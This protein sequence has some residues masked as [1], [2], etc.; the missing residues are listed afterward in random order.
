M[1][2]L[3]RRLPIGPRLTAAFALMLLTMAAITAVSFFMLHQADQHVRHIVEVNMRKLSLCETMS[4]QVHVASRVLRSMVLLQDGPRIEAEAAHLTEIRHAYDAAWTALLE[5]PASAEGLQ[6][7]ERIEAMKQRTREVNDRIVA[8]ARANRDDEARELLMGESNRDLSAWQAALDDNV[9]LQE[10]QNALEA[11]ELLAANTAAKAMLLAITLGA[12]AA[13]ALAAL[14]ITRSI[15]TPIDTA[16]RTAEAIQAGRLDT[17]VRAEG[18]DECARLL[19]AMGS[20]QQALRELVDTVRQNAESVA[21]ASAE[22]A[23]GSQDLSGRTEQQASALEQTAASMEQLSSA[24]R[25]NADNAAQAN[26]LANDASQVAAEGGEKMGR[27]VETMAAIQGSSRQIAEI[28]GVIDSIA[29]QTNLLALNAAVEAARAGEQGRGFAVVAGEVRTLAQRSADAARQIKALI[30]G[31]VEQIQVGSELVGAAGGTID[32]MVETTRHVTALI[33]EIHVAS[34][35]QS[36]G[37]D[38]VRDAVAQMDHVT[39]QNAALVEESAAAA[40]SLQVQSQ[41]LVQAVHRFHAGPQIG[42]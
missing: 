12:L 27:V 13:S 14:W 32:R 15:T 31:S 26:T 1:S 16:V 20:M 11:A 7:R 5:L 22:I 41:A 39:Q 10:K 34:R 19:R 42:R 2:T 3:L 30:T 36:T 33:G 6:M 25:Q 8:L 4:K 9:A 28:T 18:D 35:E 37:V 40:E 24:V 17:D 23:T 38:Q 29:F 21:T